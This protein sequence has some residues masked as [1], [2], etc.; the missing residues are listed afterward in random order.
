MA[1]LYAEREHGQ[2][3]EQLLSNP[4]WQEAWDAY[5]AR[6]L[7]QIEAAPSNN[8]D[9]V[10]HL[11]R[12]LTAATAAKAHMERIMKEGAIAAKMIELEESKS[13][14]RRIFG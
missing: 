9:A 1:N 12:L 3:A 8:Q 14:M 11:K 4:I 2:A 7:E 5:R 10:M 6:I 13:K